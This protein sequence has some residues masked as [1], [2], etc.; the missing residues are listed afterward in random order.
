ME[1]KNENSINVL[2]IMGDASY[3]TST[4]RVLNSRYSNVAWIMPGALSRRMICRF[5]KQGKKVWDVSLS[6]NFLRNKIIYWLIFPISIGIQLFTAAPLGILLSQKMKVRFDICIAEFYNGTLCTLFLRKIG[7]VRKVA[8]YVT[9]WFPYQPQSKVG[10]ITAIT[11][12]IVFPYLDRFCAR[13]ADATWNLT[14][15][16]ID[17]RHDRWKNR[18]LIIS[19]EEVIPPSL[20]WRRIA[21]DEKNST[22]HKSIG[23]LGVLRKGKGLELAIEAIADLKKQGKYLTLDIIGTSSQEAYYRDYVKK[24]NV[25]DRIIFHG[26]VEDETEV[27]KIL[28][29][30]ICGLA[31]YEVG[32]ENYTYYTWPSKVGFYIECGIPVII[33]RSATIADEIEKEKLGIVVNRNLKSISD[34]IYTLAID[35]NLL[36]EYKA[37]ISRFVQSRSTGD[38]VNNAI[39]RV[40]LDK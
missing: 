38:E 6:Y 24:L 40:L 34:A 39:M 31:L 33:T 2:L 13:R 35:H 12:N 19:R 14:Q 36:K 17:A 1:I 4:L 28:Q 25:E 15:R 23:F 3:A 27:I 10:F 20:T 8:Y 11:N 18:P 30:C 37:N 7:L 26:F 22:K 16:I 21:D 32:K 9:D 5:Y 29:R